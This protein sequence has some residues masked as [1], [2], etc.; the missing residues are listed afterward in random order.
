MR[1]DSDRVGMCGGM[2]LN[3]NRR[4]QLVPPELVQR[5]QQWGREMV[6]WYATDG[7]KSRSRSVSGSWGAETDP[8]RQ[9]HS[10]IG[11][12][13]CAL[14]FSLD[15]QK[16]V[17]WSASIG[18]DGGRDMVLPNSGLRLDVKTTLPHRRLI[19]SKAVNHLYELKSFDALVSIS[20]DDF[21][22]TRTWIEGWVGKSQ[23]LREKQVADGKAIGRGLTEGTWFFEKKDLHNIDELLSWES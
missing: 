10:K 5:A 8:I 21:E 12:V 3:P 15:P 4:V 23:F 14:C 18:G 2:K 22:P 19:W 6:A 16:V 7:A 9:A 13:S 17:A 1:A 20:I 11:E